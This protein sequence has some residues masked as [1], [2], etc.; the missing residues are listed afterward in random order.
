M[1]MT[2]RTTAITSRRVR[3]RQTRA[4]AL[5]QSRRRRSRAPQHVR[6]LSFPFRGQIF[7]RPPLPRPCRRRCL[8][9]AT[10]CSGGVKSCSWSRRRVKKSIRSR[11]RSK[12]S[13]PDCRR[14]TAQQRNRRSRT[15]ALAFPQSP[16]T[17]TKR[18]PSSTST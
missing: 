15:P 18:K 5:R 11:L 8:L 13:P 7:L 6:R 14:P 12:N 3:G 2:A 17:K 10:T 1:M 16:Q 9:Q 4:F